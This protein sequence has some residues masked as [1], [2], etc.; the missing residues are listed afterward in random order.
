ML[1]DVGAGPGKVWEHVAPAYNRI[2]GIEPN[3]AM[4]ASQYPP[5]CVYTESPGL[6]YLANNAVTAGGTVAWLWSLNYALLSFF[7]KYDPASKAVRVLACP[8]DASREAEQALISA[9][10]NTRFAHWFVAF[11]DDD[12]VEQ[13]LVTRI[14]RRDTPYPFDDRAYTRRLFERVAASWASQ[15]GLRFTASR[16]TGEAD[17][18]SMN[19]AV[20]NFLVFQLRGHFNH[21]D[22]VIRELRDELGK[23]IRKGRVILPAGSYFYEIAPARTSATT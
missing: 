2:T 11:F 14:W 9:L 8:E 20:E 13:R 1:T 17:Y 6:E 7:E 4:W 16:E 21:N 18:G 23:W 15:K 3:R 10:K 12:T 5:N 22:S 19:M